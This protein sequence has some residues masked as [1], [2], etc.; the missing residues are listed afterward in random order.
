MSKK[1]VRIISLFQYY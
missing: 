1:S